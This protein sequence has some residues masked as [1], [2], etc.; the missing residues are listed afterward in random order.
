VKLTTHLRLV[1]RLRMRGAIPPLPIRL[2]DVMRFKNVNVSFA[3]IFNVCIANKLKFLVCNQP[4]A[5]SGLS[6]TT[7]GDNA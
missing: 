7:R 4:S 3:L 6:H 2:N 1:L 5:W